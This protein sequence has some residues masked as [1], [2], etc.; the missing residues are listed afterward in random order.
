MRLGDSVALECRSGLNSEVRAWRIA[1][2]QPF[3]ATAQ[4]SAKQESS[5]SRQQTAA[6]EFGTFLLKTAMVA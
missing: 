4:E 2:K 6:A 3:L 5:S 1:Y